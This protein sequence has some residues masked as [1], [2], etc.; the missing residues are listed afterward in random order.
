MSFRQPGAF[1][2]QSVARSLVSA[3]AY[4]IAS[5]L[6]GL[7]AQAAQIQPESVAAQAAATLQSC[8]ATAVADRGRCRKTAVAGAQE[9][10]TP[11]E[12]AINQQQ[13]TCMLEVLEALRPNAPRT[14]AQAR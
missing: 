6:G 5:V 7:S 9:R 13:R 4:A 3:I 8:T 11:C 10:D 12:D 1:G 2:G 14:P